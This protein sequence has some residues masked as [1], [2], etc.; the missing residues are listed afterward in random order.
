MIDASEPD[1]ALAAFAP[2]ERHR[3]ARWTT[4]P[5]RGRGANRHDSA[6]RADS[7]V[8]PGPVS[9][10]GIATWWQHASESFGTA[11][12]RCKGIV[13]IRE[14]NEVV[15][16]QGVAR[17]FHSPERL[18]GWPDAD[19]RSRLV[20]ITRGVDADALRA[21][22][23]AFELEPGAEPGGPPLP[24]VPLPKSTQRIES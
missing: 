2:G 9:W 14:T 6:I 22:L 18:P 11:M 13:Q 5:A 1:A 21:T 24:K 7:F 23:A 8:L 4:R 16:L 20:C 10:S 12:L 3:V 15:F 17:V 19:H